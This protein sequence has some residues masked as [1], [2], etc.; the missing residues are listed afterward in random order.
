MRIV[1][2]DNFGGDYP[3]ESFINLPHYL[4]ED[5]CKKIA[6]IINKEAGANSRRFWKIVPNEYNLAPKFEP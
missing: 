5:A 6:D 1:N 4:S 2:T 3:N